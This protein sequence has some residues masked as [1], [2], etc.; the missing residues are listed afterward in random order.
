MA[1][2][3]AGG[4]GCYAGACATVGSFGGGRGVKDGRYA[5]ARGGSKGRFGIGCVAR[6][7]TRPAYCG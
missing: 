1:S 5:S 2:L 7:R 4:Q 3:R 6:G